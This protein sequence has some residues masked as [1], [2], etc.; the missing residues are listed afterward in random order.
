MMTLLAGLPFIP[1]LSSMKDM[2]NFIPP[3]PGELPAKAL[4][5]IKGTY[6]NA[7]Y[8]H[9]MSKGSHAAISSY[10]NE[11]LYN[12]QG[13]RYDMDTNRR[14]AKNLFAKLINAQPEEIAWVASTMVGENCIVNGLS[15]PGSR[16]RVV[17]DAFHFS[18]SLFMYN[19][20]A[21]Q[22]LDVQVVRPRDNRISLDDYEAAIT[23]GTK[24]V[25]VSLV[26]AYNGYQ[27]DLKKLCD[28]AHAKNA[29]VYAD[30]I[31]AAG[32]V[33]ID[34]K[35][36]GVDFCASATYKWLMGDFGLGFLYVRKDKLHLL[37]RSQI[38]YRQEE[39]MVSHV[40]PY[41]E[42]G[43]VMFETE[44]RTDAAGYFEVGTFANEAIAALR[45]SLEYLVTTGPAK[46]QAYRLPM[47]QLL[48]SKLPA[49]GFEP[50]T[51]V[52]S[53]S[54]IVSFSYKDAAKLKPRLEAAGISISLYKDRIRIS[55]SIYNDTADMLKLINALS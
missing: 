33:P 19:E 31:Q 30:I 25:A 2:E 47:L 40:Y 11:R 51:P 37:K 18:G 48:Q 43:T 45:H 41:D 23:S 8:T 4:F 1:A 34:V 3:I 21:K 17:T 27:H 7:A 20:L 24:L 49:L 5:D 55:P 10:L 42:P 29:L 38:G 32:A 36:S 46:I 16:A 50:L 26:S 13:P 35:E 52:D 22:G 53:T 39:K 12:G 54:P 14:E 9:P 6:L 44:S 28:M 15:L